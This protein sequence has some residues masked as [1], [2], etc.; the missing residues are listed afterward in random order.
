MPIKKI[1]KKVSQLAERKT[2]K[3]KKLPYTGGKPTVSKLPS[4][5]GEVK[6]ALMSKKAVKRAP[7]GATA[8]STMMRAK[9]PNK[10]NG[11]STA[12]AR[13]EKLAGK[14]KKYY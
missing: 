13:A 4:N 8:D 5:G 2:A 1:K 6:P 9:H 11:L 10:D 14:K 7:A 12:A 3:P